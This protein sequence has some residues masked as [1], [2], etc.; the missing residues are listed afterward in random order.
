L[1]AT[2][3]RGWFI[4]TGR[5]QETL[6]RLR[7]AGEVWDL[8]LPPEGSRVLV[9]VQWRLQQGID[10]PT[11][12]RFL[13][14]FTERN[15][16]LWRRTL[17]KDLQKV[18]AIPAQAR[19]LLDVPVGAVGGGGVVQEELLVLPLDA[20][21][22]WAS[23]A[24]KLPTAFTE[25]LAFFQRQVFQRAV[26]DN[27]G[28]PLD[29]AKQALLEQL[30]DSRQV[31]QRLAVSSLAAC[32]HVEELIRILEARPQAFLRQATREALHYWLG[33]YPHRANWL[34]ELM[35]QKL[36]YERAQANLLVELL[37]GY[38]GPDRATAEYLLKI[39]QDEKSAALRYLA[40]ANLRELYPQLRD[41]YRPDD[42]DEARAKAIA[43]I[44]KQLP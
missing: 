32:D 26:V 39:M 44:R 18:A 36:R 1:D 22:A 2:L 27:P 9:S 29:G 35:V 7:V 14:L 13:A 20:L 34:R 38:K 19:V 23:P 8:V 37:R 21:P 4:I 41:S 30:D 33:Q 11:A 10:P 28:R 43:A 6:V 5:K 16:V 12:Q 24:A 15:G 42:S 40:V 25:A 3:E 31:V 17:S